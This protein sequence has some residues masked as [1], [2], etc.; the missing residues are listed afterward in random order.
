VKFMICGL[1][2]GVWGSG[3]GSGGSDFSF[4]VQGSGFRAQGAWFFEAGHS[5]C[6][7]LTGL[8]SDSRHLGSSRRGGALS[9]GLGRS[10]PKAI[11]A[12]ARV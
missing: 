8:P 9:L 1:R 11:N 5:A 2:F 10:F 3:L 4:R 6:S 7:R 12:M